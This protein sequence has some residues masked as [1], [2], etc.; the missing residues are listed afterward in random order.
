MSRDKTHKLNR[1]LLLGI[2]FVSALIP[3][4]QVPFFYKR[5]VVKPVEFVREVFI[6]VSPSVEVFAP[7]IEIASLPE[8]TGIHINPWLVFYLIAISF[9]VL[10]LAISVSRIFQLYRRSERI[11]FHRFVL[12]VVKDHIQPFSFV[13]HIFI[14]EKD[15]ESNQ[16]ILIAHEAE[17]IRQKHHIDL[18]L[19]EAFT[20]FHWFNPFVWLLRRDLK[21]VHEYQA[22][23]AVLQKGIDA[24]RYQLLVLK[25]AVG[26]RRFAMANHFVQKPIFKRM[27]MMKNNQTN[28]WGGLKLMYFFPL[29]ILMLQAFTRPDL[30]QRTEELIPSVFQKNEQEK[31][32]EK[33]TSEEI[34]KGFFDPDIRTE[35]SLKKDN[36]VLVIL[37]NA[38]DEYLI[39]GEYHKAVEIKSIVKSFLYGKNP[40]GKKGPDYLEKQIPAIGKLKVSQGIISYKHDL[41]SSSEMVNNTI[42]AIGEGC[43]EVRNEKAKVLFDREYF[44][45]DDERQEAV[46]KAV[47]I[48]FSYMSPKSPTPNV[49]LPFERKPS[50]PGPIKITFKGN[51]NVTVENHKFDSFEEFEE[52]LKYWTREL[53]EFNK[54]RRSQGFYR[55]N[56]TYED[57]PRSE[58]K[59]IDYILYKNNVHVEHLES[60]VEFTSVIIQ[61]KSDSNE[62]DLK[63]IRQKAEKNFKKYNGEFNVLIQYADG[64]TEEQI[65]AVEDIYKE[66]GV[67]NISAKEYER[68]SLPLLLIHLYPNEVKNVFLDTISMEDVSE[69]TTS[70]LEKVRSEYLAAI[71]AHQNVSEERIQQLK[72]KIR[73]GGVEAQISVKKLN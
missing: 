46:D 3:F 8:N 66:L 67:K 36:N 49:W 38:N 11:G 19:L 5:T 59:N 14:S 21:L 22:D 68:P 48:W 58:Q 47:P 31:W 26:E 35:S 13:K 7:G 17:H 23:Q 43:M 55:A 4:V 12:A 62:A 71:Y 1:F 24:K 33:W 63:D 27:K 69:Y 16:E 18:F 70:W 57:I 51:G 20:L 37:M 2:L 73:D 45:L 34:G 30:I 65:K 25:K 42:R 28:R 29:I 64:V 44:A 53:D 40:D 10:R 41:A 39:E 54:D 72:E 15:Y 6:P 50:P 32:L 9:L 56:V 60:N 61:I 52:N